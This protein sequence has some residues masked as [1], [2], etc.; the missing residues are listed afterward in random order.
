MLM[1]LTSPFSSSFP[2][3]SENQFSWTTKQ[4]HVRSYSLTHSLVCVLPSFLL[5]SHCISFLLLC[6]F[7][8]CFFCDFSPTSFL[9]LISLRIFFKSFPYLPRSSFPLPSLR[10][11]R[12]FLYHGAIPKCC[13]FLSTDRI[14]CSLTRSI[15]SNFLFQFPSS[16][17]P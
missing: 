3:A 8:H 16:S 9:F 10:T 7:L 14:T 1:Y 12:P 6:L 2:A 11:P 4:T 17:H 13:A 5:L 15:L